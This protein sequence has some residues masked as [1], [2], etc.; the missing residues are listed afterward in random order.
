M[1]QLFAVTN[2]PSCLS[3]CTV[4]HD[5]L[6][7]TLNAEVFSCRRV[8]VDNDWFYV[9]LTQDAEAG[10]PHTTGTVRVQVFKDNFPA[11]QAARLADIL[12]GAAEMLALDRWDTHGIG[13]PGIERPVSTRILIERDV[14]TNLSSV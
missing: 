9:A 7:S 6:D 13:T 10:H 8:F 1:T 14:D 3:W 12:A 11:D 4:E 5:P 2:N